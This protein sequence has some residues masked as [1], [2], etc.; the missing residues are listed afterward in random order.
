MYN[1]KYVLFGN[2]P[3]DLKILKMKV[4]LRLKILRTS[5]LDVLVC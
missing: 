4:F 1:M 2:I 3:L 5:F